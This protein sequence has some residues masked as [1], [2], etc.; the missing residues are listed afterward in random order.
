MKLS[1]L[2]FSPSGVISGEG[3]DLNGQFTILGQMNGDSIEFD[4]HY[5]GKHHIYYKG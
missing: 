2:N 1:E 5:T 3:S 4:K